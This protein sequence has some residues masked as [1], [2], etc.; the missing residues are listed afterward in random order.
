MASLIPIT[1]TET[2]AG[3]VKI[4]FPEGGVSHLIGE[5]FQGVNELYAQTGLSKEEQSA[6]THQIGEYV[7]AFF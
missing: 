6:M 5:L 7:N 1:H 4:R 3:V 2:V